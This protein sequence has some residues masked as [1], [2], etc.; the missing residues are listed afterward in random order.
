MRLF[1]Q[2]ATAVQATG[3]RRFDNNG[4]H[5]RL[6]FNPESRLA[7]A[8]VPGDGN[9]GGAS[10]IARLVA[11]FAGFFQKSDAG[12]IGRRHIAGESVGFSPRPATVGIQPQP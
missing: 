2:L 6:C 12:T 4:G 8:F 11:G 7:H 3:Q 1:H 9:A 5:A 10:E